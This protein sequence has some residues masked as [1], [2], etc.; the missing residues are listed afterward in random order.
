MSAAA[1]NPLDRSQTEACLPGETFKLRG[2]NLEKHLGHLAD[3]VT[4]DSANTPDHQT[5][6]GAFVN[7]CDSAFEQPTAD[8]GCVG[9]QAGRQ[10]VG[11]GNQLLADRRRKNTT[12]CK[13]CF[14]PLEDLVDLFG[15][16]HQLQEEGWGDHGV[17][18]IEPRSC[19]QLAL[20][21]V[22][23]QARRDS[24]PHCCKKER[25][26]VDSDYFRSRPE[27]NLPGNTASAATKLGDPGRWKPRR[28]PGPML[29]VGC[30]AGM[31]QVVPQHQIRPR[32]TGATTPSAASRPRSSVMAV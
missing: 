18:P 32:Q 17:H 21:S 31:L 28:D 25:I 2:P 11:Y 1:S 6:V 30:V 14:R 12:S 8:A 16:V 4:I 13:R 7:R 23:S 3:V 9:R 20:H 26:P 24:R 15:I 29:E 5:S 27:G 19:R 10:L 22:D